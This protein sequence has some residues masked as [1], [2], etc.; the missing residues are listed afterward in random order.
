[1]EKIFARKIFVSILEKNLLIK[2][3]TVLFSGGIEISFL[4]F[5]TIIYVESKLGEIWANDQCKKKQHNLFE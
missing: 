5:H 4:K 2:S 3:V 1:M